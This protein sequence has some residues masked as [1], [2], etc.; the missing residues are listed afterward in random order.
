MC[1]N[2]WPGINL[3]SLLLDPFPSISAFHIPAYPLGGQNINHGSNHFHNNIN[4]SDKW[5]NKRLLIIKSERDGSIS[6]RNGRI[7]LFNLPFLL[8]ESS[9]V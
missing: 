5:E 7:Y 9:W 4:S 3:I 2:I 1:E 8:K 6:E